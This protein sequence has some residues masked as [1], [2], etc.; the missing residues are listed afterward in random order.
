MAGIRPCSGGSQSKRRRTHTCERVWTNTYLRVTKE[1]PPG[2]GERPSEQFNSVVPASS[3]IYGVGGEWLVQVQSEDK[4]CA[5]PTQYITG[6]KHQPECQHG[7]VLLFKTV[8]F[9]GDEPE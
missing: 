3:R 4:C 7:Q 5:L 2:S 8:S 9:K 1:R 6:K